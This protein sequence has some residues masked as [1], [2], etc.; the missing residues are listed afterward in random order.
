MFF[1]HSCFK[2]DE[3][4]VECFKVFFMASGQIQGSNMDQEKLEK[5]PAK[6]LCFLLLLFPREIQGIKWKMV[7]FYL[8]SNNCVEFRVL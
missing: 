3:F 7:F 2:E 6:R 1:N 8:K 4:L 5:P